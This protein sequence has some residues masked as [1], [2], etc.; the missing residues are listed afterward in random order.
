[1]GTYSDYEQ[2]LLDQQTGEEMDRLAQRREARD[3]I[4]TAPIGTAHVFADADNNGLNARVLPEAKTSNLVSK[5]R[6]VCET[7]VADDGLV[8]LNPDD[9]LGA[10]DE[11]RRA[12]ET[13]H[14]LAPSEAA[15]LD[16]VLARSPRR[17]ESVLDFKVTVCS[18]CL[19]ASCWLGEFYCEQHR[20]ASTVI[21]TVRELHALGPLED[22]GWWFKGADTGKVNYRFLEAYQSAVKTGCSAPLTADPARIDAEQ[23]PEGPL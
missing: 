21:K 6:T 20:E 10:F 5:V 1:M 3:T 16:K 19:Q 13:T 23:F 8:L 14:E 9:V 2:R 18:E 17:V 12:G 22:A 11:L 7:S 4:A 15:S